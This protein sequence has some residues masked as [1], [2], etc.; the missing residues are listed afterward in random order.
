MQAIVPR[1]GLPRFS[2]KPLPITTHLY[3]YQ[4]MRNLIM[5]MEEIDLEPDAEQFQ[6]LCIALQR[7]TFSCLN[8]ADA[9][10]DARD[11]L[12]SSPL[13]IRKLFHNQPHCA[14]R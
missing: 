7:A 2:P 5:S 13:Y 6:L 12:S 9:G 8:K 11:L 14:A 1:S 4:M 3:A 10:T